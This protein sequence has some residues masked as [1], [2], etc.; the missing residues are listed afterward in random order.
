MRV[1]AA[2]LWAHVLRVTL[3]SS[4]LAFA[5]AA[6]APAVVAPSAP[7]THAVPRVVWPR[8]AEVQS[9]PTVS[10]P[11]VNRGHAGMGP[12]AVVRVSPEARVT[13]THL[14][15]ESVLPDGAVVALFHVGTAQGPGSTYVMQK[16]AGVWSFMTLDGGGVE[17]GNAV[18]SGRASEACRRCHAD[19]VADSLFGMPRRS[20]SAP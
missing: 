7:P 6:P 1:I 4:F 16:S 18:E 12:L 19:G 8:F 5:C 10:A 17:S 14:V 2:Q 15:Q 3:L 11:F 9:W 13:Y 20:T